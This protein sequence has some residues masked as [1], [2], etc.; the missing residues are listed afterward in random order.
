[1]S[2]TTLL[3]MPGARGLFSK[4]IAQS[5]AAHVGADPEDARLVTRELSAALGFD[6]T[7]ASLAEVDL[8]K[9]IEAHATVRDAMAV[10]PDPARYGASIVATGMA[11]IP[12][13]DGDVLPVHPL[14]ALAAGAGGWI[15]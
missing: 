9:L 12:V 14:A 13:A 2:V 15:K 3:G 7:A 4:A 6:A 1:M 11:L 10:A 8:D 5:G